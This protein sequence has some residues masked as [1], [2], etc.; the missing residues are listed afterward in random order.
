MPQEVSS[1][2]QEAIQCS[3]P[4]KRVSWKS[5]AAATMRGIVWG[6]A[7]LRAQLLYL[8]LSYPVKALPEGLKGKTSTR[9][10][11]FDFA[12]DSGASVTTTH[13]EVPLI[14]EISSACLMIPDKEQRANCKSLHTPSD[15]TGNL[16]MPRHLL[17]VEGKQTLVN[18]AAPPAEPTDKSDGISTAAPPLATVPTAGPALALTSTALAASFLLYSIR[19]FLKDLGG[20]VSTGSAV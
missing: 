19:C 13:G 10:R 6:H 16:Q 18:T 7:A 9:T 20:H 4:P 14:A 5:P 1:N 2:A 8:V 12:L 11:R 15:R 17:A 3:V